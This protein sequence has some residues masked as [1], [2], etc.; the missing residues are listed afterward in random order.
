MT[1]SSLRQQGHG[2]LVALANAHPVLFALG[3]VL[4]I[5]VLYTLGTV[6]A[7]WDYSAR[8]DIGS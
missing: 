7:W 6:W 5:F 8:A 3:L 4:V 1:Y 2:R